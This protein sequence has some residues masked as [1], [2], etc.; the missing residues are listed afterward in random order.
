M[1]HKEVGLNW[2][3]VLCE[4][5][6]STNEEFKSHISDHH[7]DIDKEY[8]K[9]GHELFCCNICN[10]ESN[11]PEYIKKHLAEHTLT[12]KIVL[13]N[14]VKSKEEFKAR[15]KTKDWHN[16]YDEFGNPL[17]DEEEWHFVVWGGLFS[18][19]QT[20]APWVVE[21][22]WGILKCSPWTMIYKGTELEAP[23]TQRLRNSSWLPIT[24]SQFSFD[25]DL[26]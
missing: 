20:G 9:S 18:P 26:K 7:E 23:Q 6:F 16:A 17:Y 8:L 14:N 4:D 22:R 24:W 5:I 13:T 25:Q 10:F 21:G 15:L 11:N 3:S 2:R 12:P 19:L 1:Q